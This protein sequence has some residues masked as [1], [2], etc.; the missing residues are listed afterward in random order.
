MEAREETFTIQIAN[1]KVGLH[2]E[3]AFL[4]RAK[5]L[6]D[7]M[8]RFSSHV[9]DT[10]FTFTRHDQPACQ[11]GWY[12]KEKMLELAKL[13]ECTSFPLIRAALTRHAD[14][15]PSEFVEEHAVSLSNWANGCAPD[16]S[17]REVETAA[18]T[19]PT[20]PGS[21]AKF[22]SHQPAYITDLSRSRSYIFDHSASMD[23][24]AHPEI[25]P[26]HG[27]TTTPGTNAGPL[28]PL[29]TFA[30]TNIHSDVL[31]TPLEQYSDTYIGYDPDFAKKRNNKLL[32]RGST[33]G[34]NFD[35]YSDWRASQRS[36]LHFMTHEKGGQREVL[37]DEKEREGLEEMSVEVKAMNAAY[38]DVSFSGG[39]VQCDA[40]TCNLM[41]KTIDFAPTM[42]LDESYQVRPFRCPLSRHC[43]RV[44]LTRAQ[45]K[46][47]MDV[48]GNGWSGRFHRLMSMKALVLKSTLFPEWYSERV[49]PW[50][51]CVPPSAPAQLSLIGI[52]SY[53]PVKVDYTDLYDVMT[54]FRG[55]PDGKGAH[56]EIAAKIGLA[57]KR[58]AR[59]HVR[60]SSALSG[61]LLTLQ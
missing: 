34:V 48:D 10:N 25:M 57:G 3:Q 32:W 44:A 29:F 54:F 35:Q 38:M 21:G 49:Q 2:G 43:W 8:A 36:R 33:T 60:L 4:R 14:F 5:D 24:C 22:K 56:E 47:V 40:R 27:F 52:E 12:H 18:L 11:L 6:G 17:L 37:V 31:V 50:V 53:V 59:D 42:G 23:I 46:Y 19:Q 13:G 20:T 41:S 28:V 7:L 55:T 39:P 51:Q 58:W 45:Y 26:I 30:K 61:S 15:G 1:G 9:G 16:S